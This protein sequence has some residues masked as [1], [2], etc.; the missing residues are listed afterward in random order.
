MKENDIRPQDLLARYVELSA[1]DAERCFGHERRYD[2]PCVACG[3]TQAE[4]QF[5]KTG[6]A[7]AQ[8]RQCGTLYQSPRPPIEAFSAF[9]RDSES[10]RYWAEVFFP[11]VA[12]ARREKIFRPRVARLRQWCAGRGV[13]V[14]RLM[15]VGAGYGIFLDEW[16]HCDPAVDAVAVEPSSH[17][18]KECRAKGLEVVEE[19]AEN[20]TG[21]DG[22]A[23]L[24]TCFEVLE[25]VHD[26]LAFVISLR[27]LVRPGGI[28]F[29]STLSIEGFDLQVLWERSTQISPPH[30]I[31]FLSIEGFR[32][33]F[34][35]A[36]LVDIDVST[37]GQLDVD[38]V[39]NALNKNS[40]TLGQ[41]RFVGALLKDEVAEDFQAFL[42]RNRL[43]SHA[44]VFG[45]K[46][47]EEK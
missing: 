44:W 40:G 16:R 13:P 24:V 3:S 31:N 34:A 41:Q 5:V 36:G 45:R 10:S 7:Y 17:L 37:P 35:S 1:Q 14:R 8:C 25:H 9:Y 6:F 29:V 43:S 2:I 38:I 12:E 23:D 19:V 42:A 21:M 39:R 46:A 28:L 22:R 15:D 30:H 18:A 11:A 4:P 27:R 20:V 32:R 33:L 47:L 26:P